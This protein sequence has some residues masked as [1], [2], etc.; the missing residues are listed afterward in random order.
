MFITGS[1]D[2]KAILW[3]LNGSALKVWNGHR[4]HDVVVSSDGSKMVMADSECTIR[5]YDLVTD[6]EITQDSKYCLISERANLL[7][8]LDL[9]KH[10]IVR[11]IRV[12]SHNQGLQVKQLQENPNEACEIRACFGGPNDEY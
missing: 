6:T 1:L 9:E 8:V 3:D 2:K 4:A 11:E 5:I 10:E 7:T 12:N